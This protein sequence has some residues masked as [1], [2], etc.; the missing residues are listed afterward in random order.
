MTKRKIARKVWERKDQQRERAM[1]LVQEAERSAD[2]LEVE[3]A[4]LFWLERWR[5]TVH[6]GL[7]RLPGLDFVWPLT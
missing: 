6:P 2:P 7:L 1:Q 5:G 4:A 3:A